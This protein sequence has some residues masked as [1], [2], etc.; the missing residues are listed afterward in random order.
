MRGRDVLRSLSDGLALTYQTEVPIIKTAFKL[1]VLFVALIATRPAHAQLKVSDFF[2]DHMVIQRAQPITV[3]GTAPAGA[4]VTAAIADKTA[5]AKAAADGRW[6][7]TLPAA[8]AAGPFELKVS[9]GTE[10]QT[11]KDVMIGDVW[12]ISGQSNVVLTLAAS[13]EGA[14]AKKNDPPNNLVRVC[15]LPGSIA[16][17]PTEALSRHITWDPLNAARVSA[18]LS[19]VGYFFVH[20]LQPAAGVAVGL[21]QSSA[22]GTQVEQWT[23][24][25]ALKAAAPDNPLFATRD[26]AKAKFDADPKAKIGVTEAGATSLYNGSIH[27]FHLAKLKGV[28]WYQGE[29]N[30]R[31]KRDYRPVLT[32]FVK[33]LREVF[34]EPD[35]PFVIVQLPAN[36]LPKDDGWM[37][38]Q[39]AQ[40]LVAREM[41]LALV[42]TIDQGSPVTIHPPNKAE[43]GRRTALAAIQHV[44]K[45]EVEGTSPFAKSVTFTGDTATVEFEG[46]KG[47]LVV[48][49]DSILGFELAGTD[50][51]FAPATATLQGRRVLVKAAA[52]P[53]PKSLRYLWVH[54]PEAVTLWSA[55]GLPAGPFRSEAVNSASKQ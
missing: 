1:V 38:V 30:T 5:T 27:P 14:E 33:A 49:G 18:Y 52:M 8:P 29:A 42:V 3:W 35:L 4:D 10:T 19:G 54:S 51:V 2:A 24:E 20:D 6:Q 47:D 22:G 26:V 12:L 39:E 40:M 28:V 9:S 15:K 34:G 32:A 31:S 11:I 50:G 48:K 44:Y 41:G 25:A 36:G 13:T 7:A 23:P 37:R 16:F 55:A 17:A 46:F 43:V 21:I 53:A 45:P